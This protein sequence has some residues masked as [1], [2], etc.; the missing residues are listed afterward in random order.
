MQTYFNLTRRNM[1][2]WNDAV[3]KFDLLITKSIN[4]NTN[5]TT[6]QPK[7]L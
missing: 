7:W 6:K 5:P 1:G 4:Y 2:T 3:L